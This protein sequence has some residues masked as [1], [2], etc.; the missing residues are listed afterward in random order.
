MPNPIAQRLSE[1]LRTLI[2]A[3]A[4]VAVLVLMAVTQLP[5]DARAETGSEG[6]S[7]FAIYVPKPGGL[8]I[9]FS[10]FSE[11]QSF[12]DAVPFRVLSISV[13]DNAT[14]RFYVYIPGAPER[15]NTLTRE[16]FSSQSIVFI[17]RHSADVGGAPAGTTFVPEP[18]AAQVARSAAAP[19]GQPGSPSEAAPAG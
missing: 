1:H 3:I 4:T 19:A 11:P 9:G 10:G 6:Q 7:P 15:V 12:V 2:V 16:N 5:G 14:Q 17:R 13:F 8:T 18:F